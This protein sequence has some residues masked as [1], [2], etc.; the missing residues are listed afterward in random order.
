MRWPWES[1]VLR[2]YYPDDG[3]SKR[4]AEGRSKGDHRRPISLSF[5]GEVINGEGA[6][7]SVGG[8]DLGGGGNITGARGGVGRFPVNQ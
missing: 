2:A 7:R 6:E 8:G 1:E 5:G 3:R 4:W